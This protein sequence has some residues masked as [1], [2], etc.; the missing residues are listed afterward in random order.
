MT[1]ETT[2]ATNFT[3]EKDGDELVGQLTGVK[4]SKFSKVYDLTKSEGKKV[5]FYGCAYLD[6]ALHNRIGK[7]VRIVYQGKKQL[8]GGK[9]LKVFDVNIWTADDGSLPEGFEELE[10]EVQY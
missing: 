8:E 3:F 5:F 9:T 4:D 10:E 6:R 7:I 1:W 2:E